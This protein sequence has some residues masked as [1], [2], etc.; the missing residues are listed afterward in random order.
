M[1][2]K[3]PMDLFI[4]LF[5]AKMI[6]L[7]YLLLPGFVFLFVGIWVKWCLV[8]GAVL[9]LLVIMIALLGQ[10]RD[11][12]IVL[13]S[14]DPKDKDFQDAVL[15]PNWKDNVIRMTEDAVNRH[16]NGDSDS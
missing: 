5:I 1:K 6:K 12:H 15:S 4:L 8:T 2:R 13:H 14:N 7:Y 11:R 10:L 9:F 16:K 3:Y